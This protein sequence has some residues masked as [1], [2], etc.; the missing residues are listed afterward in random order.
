MWWGSRPPHLRPHAINE[1]H[2][3]SIRALT[4]AKGL[5]A[6]TR[7]V[8]RNAAVIERSNLMRKVRQRGT[9][10]ELAVRRMLRQISVSYRSN[11]KALPGS[12]DIVLTAKKKA[13]V[14]HGC[15]W[16]RHKGCKAASTPKTR[17]D[18]WSDKFKKNV[19][20]D[21]KTRRQLNTLG[22]SVMVIWECQAT[23]NRESGNVLKRLIRFALQKTST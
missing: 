23:G 1:L 4:T 8:Q 22:Y 2:R 13:I 12:P 5:A 19:A 3:G 10:P 21:R 20:R 7:N 6:D 14:V 11:V 15:Y 9:A 16:H 17:V 18:F